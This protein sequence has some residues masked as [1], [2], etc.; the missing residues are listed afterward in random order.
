MIVVKAFFKLY[1]LHMFAIF[2]IYK[3]SQKRQHTV[4]E[5]KEISKACLVLTRPLRVGA[6][7]PKG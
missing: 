2:N 4:Q 5:S 6:F 3:G 7:T 1:G